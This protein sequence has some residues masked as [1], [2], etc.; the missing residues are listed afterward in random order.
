[1]GLRSLF[2]GLSRVWAST[3]AQR[4]T[5][6]FVRGKA[7]VLQEPSVIA[8]DLDTA[9]YSLWDTSKRWWVALCRHSRSPAPQRRGHRDLDVTVICSGRLS[10]RPQGVWSVQAR[11]VIGVPSEV[12]QVE[13]RSSM[14]RRSRPEARGVLIGSQWRRHRRRASCRRNPGNM[15]VDIGGGTM[16]WHV[17]SLGGIVASVHYP[18]G[19]KMDEAIVAI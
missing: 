19:D 2:G 6:V 15:V 13:R 11:I 9:T 14:T 16:R 3:S 1:M 8:M 18:A 12:T 5:L 7:F 17:I 4:N 10:R